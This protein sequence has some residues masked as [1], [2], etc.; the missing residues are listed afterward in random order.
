MPGIECGRV[1]PNYVDVVKGIS[2]W[3]KDPNTKKLFVDPHEAA[4]RL[5]ENDFLIPLDTL[6]YAEGLTKGQA[7]SF[8]GRLKQYTDKVESGKLDN[9]F[10]QYFWQSSHYGKKDPSI[11]QFLNNAQQSSFHFRA[12]E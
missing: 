9:D 10:F 6:K 1:N 4:F 11:G 3:T 5:A 7:E 8:L 2:E 12:N